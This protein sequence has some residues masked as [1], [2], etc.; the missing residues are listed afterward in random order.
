MCAYSFRSFQMENEV[1]AVGATDVATHGV[2]VFYP[3]DEISNHSR[4]DLHFA[5]KRKQVQVLSR[6]PQLVRKRK[7]KSTHAGRQQSGR[8]LISRR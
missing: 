3:E 4:N 5:G 6:N 7:T 2:S 8:E 1:A